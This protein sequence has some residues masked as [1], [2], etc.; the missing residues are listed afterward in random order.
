MVHDTVAEFRRPYLAVLRSVDDEAL[1]AP[2]DIAVVEQ[3]GVQVNEV[4][5]QVGLEGESAGRVAFRA[6]AVAVSLD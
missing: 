2:R 3:L 5:L 4:A 6:P 1:R